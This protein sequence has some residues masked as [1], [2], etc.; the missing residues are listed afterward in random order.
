MQ[1]SDVVRRYAAALLEAAAESQISNQVGQDVERLAAVLRQSPE[2]ISRLSNRLLSASAQQSLLEALFAGRVEQL[3]LNFL[4]LLAERRRA[5]LL[6]AVLDAFLALADAQ[7][8]K[9]VGQLRSAVELSAEQVEQVRQRLTAYTGKQVRLQIQVDKTLKGGL[10]AQ[11]G[12]TVFD[13]SLNT[14]LQRLC[15]RLVEARPLDQEESARR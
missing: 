10:I 6:P 13:A 11:V 14:Q 8:G 12:D 3:T 15:R 9:A 2:L 1:T 4:R 5:A 7:E